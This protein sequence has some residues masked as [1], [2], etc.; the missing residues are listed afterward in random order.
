M[1]SWSMS[2]SFAITYVD[3]WMP[4]KYTDSIG[5]MTLMNTMCDKSQFVVI[6]LVTKKI[7]AVFAENVFQHVLMKFDL[8]HIVVVDDG[9][10]FICD[11]V[12]MSKTV[13]L[14]FDIIFKRNHKGLTVEYFHR[15]LNNVVTI[16]MEDRQSDD[17]FVRPK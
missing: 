14:N 17:A 7:Y 15:F 12:A 10:P 13:D 16:A 3:L 11:F 8:C 2:S 5:N 6:V 4:S 1:F 9:N